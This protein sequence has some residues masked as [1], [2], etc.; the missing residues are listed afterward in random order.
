VAVGFICVTAKGVQGSWVFLI[1]GEAGCP[2]TLHQLREEGSDTGQWQIREERDDSGTRRGS[3]ALDQRLE[4]SS[5]GVTLINI[6]GITF[7]CP[8]L[9]TVLFMDG[10]CPFLLREGLGSFSQVG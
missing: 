8:N 1:A 10:C 6:S 3:L 7:L 2:M 4:L 5:N 9:K